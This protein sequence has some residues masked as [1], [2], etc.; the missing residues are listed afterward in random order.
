[1]IDPLAE[2]VPNLSPYHYGYNNP[3]RFFDIIGMY[4]YNWNTGN[5]QDSNG[6]VVS[7]DEVQSNNY[8]EPKKDDKE[9]NKMIQAAN[10][11]DEVVKHFY[12]LVEPW[13]GSNSP[14]DRPR[15]EKW[16][17]YNT[18]ASYIIVP[19]GKDEYRVAKTTVAALEKMMDVS[20]E[21]L[22]HAGTKSMEFG[23]FLSQMATS[24]LVIPKYSIKG[25]SPNIAVQ[26]TTR[27]GGSFQGIGGAMRIFGRTLSVY[28]YINTYLN[29]TP[30]G[31]TQL[32][33]DE[34]KIQT[35]KRYSELFNK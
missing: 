7:W 33:L 22:E 9:K 13:V 5:Y 30:G 21:L 35:A 23:K 27:L 2:I 25:S 31:P 16:A 34:I 32:S 24:K 1:V 14:F 12:S 20:G 19:E 18:L 17:I 26:N 4:S 10:N 6:N 3:I 29:V 15:D 8:V 11:K 28:S